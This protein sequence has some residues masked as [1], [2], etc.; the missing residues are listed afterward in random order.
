MAI[1][2]FAACAVSRAERNCSIYISLRLIS[3]TI[4]SK[5]SC[6]PR[7]RILNSFQRSDR[8]EGIHPNPQRERGVRASGVTKSGVKGPRGK[9]PISDFGLRN[10]PQRPDR[11][12]G[13]SIRAAS[14]SGRPLRT[15]RFPMRRPAAERDS[16]RASGTPAA[17]QP[18]DSSVTEHQAC[19]LDRL[20]EALRYPIEMCPCWGI[21]SSAIELEIGAS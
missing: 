14:A 15:Q 19:A 10:S 3:K 7:M 5:R 6:V 17:C 2:L 9:V 8:Q 4:H 1:E 20:R 18:L 11:Q 12:G 13:G 21:D 16:E